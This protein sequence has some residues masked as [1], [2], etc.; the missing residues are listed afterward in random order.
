MIRIKNQQE[1]VSIRDKYNRGELAKDILKGLAV[2]GLIVASF[3]LPNL[4]QVFSLFGIKSAKD[5]YRMKRAM[6][7]LKRQKLIEIYEKGNNEVMEITE[8]GK[9]RTLNY[10]FDD[11]NLVRPKKWDGLWRVISFDIPER[12]KRERNALTRKLKDM[13]I[14]PLQK[15]VFVCPFE[16]H[17][18]IDF[19]S[20]VLDVR[21]YIHYFSANE[22]DEKDEDFLK[23][24]YNL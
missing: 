6:E 19:V 2:G 16:C 5:R 13:E 10:K 23:R 18:E 1:K 7:S 20:E 9:K 22:M 15:S 21:K 12:Y 24:Y 3:A 14:Y 17:D 4:P 8:K 11:M